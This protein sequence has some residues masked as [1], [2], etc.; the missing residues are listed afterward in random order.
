MKLDIFDYGFFKFPL[1][2]STD[3]YW[4]S[5]LPEIDGYTMTLGWFS[6]TNKH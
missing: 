3:L 1:G 2:I 5:V 4:F 6:I